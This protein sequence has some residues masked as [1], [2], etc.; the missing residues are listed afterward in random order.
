MLGDLVM[1]EGKPYKVI[2]IDNYNSC[3]LVLDMGKKW[4]EEE[5]CDVSFVEPIPLTEEILEKNGFNDNE[6]ESMIYEDDMFLV[7]F[8]RKKRLYLRVKSTYVGAL[9]LHKHK[10]YV[11][12][13]QHAL[14]ICGFNEKADN[15]KI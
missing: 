2:E 11:H 15:F 7:S 1:F 14:R 9:S 12:E 4:Y 13:V 5:T 10:W 8:Y 6:S 3:N